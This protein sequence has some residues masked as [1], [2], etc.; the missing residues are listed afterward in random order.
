MLTL[1]A[2][3]ARALIGVALAACV[4]QPT[5]QVDVVQE[6][7]ACPDPHMEAVH[8]IDQVNGRINALWHH[9]D[10]RVS[11]SFY[12]PPQGDAFHHRLDVVRQEA[13]AMASQHGGGLGEEQHTLNG[14]LNGLQRAIQ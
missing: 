11:Q 14:E 12:P 13:R 10:Q 3:F 2:S 8:R 5:R 9:V 1:N 4:V 6:A 7:P